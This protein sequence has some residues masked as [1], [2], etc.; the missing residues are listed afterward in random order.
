MWGK[1]PVMLREGPE[2]DNSCEAKM[3]TH[4]FSPGAHPSYMLLVMYDHKMQSVHVTWSQ[5]HVLGNSLTVR[6]DISPGKWC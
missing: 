2:S 6:N 1:E 5:V 3:W 4:E